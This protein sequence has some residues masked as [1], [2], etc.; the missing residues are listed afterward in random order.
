[1][2]ERVEY[3]K[4]CHEEEGKHVFF[5][6]AERRMWSNGWEFQQSRFR[7]DLWIN[8]FPVGA[9]RRD[10]W[11]AGESVQGEA[12]QALVGA[13]LGVAIGMPWAPPGVSPIDSLL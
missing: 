3:L 9:G 12:G 1:M 11:R 8:I 13:D 5:L 10:A 7:L 4:D 2:L 6:P